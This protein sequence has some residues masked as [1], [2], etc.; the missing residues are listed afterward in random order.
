[1]KTLTPLQAKLL[2]LLS[3]GTYHS[4]QR[5]GD[6]L[7]ISRTAVWKHIEKLEALGLHIKRVPKQGYC[8]SPSF[9]PLS[10][11]RIQSLLGTQPPP[12]PTTICLPPLIQP[13][14]F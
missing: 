10:L 12:T 2:H 11:S 5:L 7:G 3:D 4:G 6:I 13:T 8:I 9:I 14:V 1:M